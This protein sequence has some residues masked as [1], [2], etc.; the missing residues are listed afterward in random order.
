MNSWLVTIGMNE[1]LKRINEA[2]FNWQFD[3]I[4]QSIYDYCH[5]CDHEEI[6]EMLNI[7]PEDDQRAFFLRL[8]SSLS[9][10][11]TPRASLHSKPANYKVIKVDYL[12]KSSRN[13]SQLWCCSLGLGFVQL[14]FFLDFKPLLMVIIN[15]FIAVKK[16][17]IDIN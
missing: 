2:E 9:V 12:I 14:F 10:K 7:R 17:I 16:L 8:K 1:M 5:P 15:R 3:M 11:G 13:I 6:R 4:G